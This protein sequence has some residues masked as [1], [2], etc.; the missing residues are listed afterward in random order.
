LAN[1]PDN[2]LDAT[3]KSAINKNLSEEERL[4]VEVILTVVPSC[5]DSTLER[6]ALVEFRG[7][8]P[9]FLSELV[10]NPLGEWQME[11]GNSDISFDCNF[12][13]FTQL[14]APTQEEPVVA[15]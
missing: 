3:L 1:Q 2:I 15:E 9:S 6:V 13:G 8:V 4:A 5:Y 14:Y 7:G 12:F 10:A 11:M